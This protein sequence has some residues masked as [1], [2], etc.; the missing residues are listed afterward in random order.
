MK[1][2]AAIQ[3]TIRVGTGV[4]QNLGC[5]TGVIANGY[6]QGCEFPIGPFARTMLV[7]FGTSVYVSTVED[8]ET[9]DFH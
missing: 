3:L 8:Q 7:K 5:L 1:G 2:T 6:V 9:N 4:D